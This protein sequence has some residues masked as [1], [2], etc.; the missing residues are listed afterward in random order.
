MKS[1]KLPACVLFII[2]AAAFVMAWGFPARALRASYFPLLF[3]GVGI[4][5]SAYLFISAVWKERAKEDKPGPQL[6]LSTKILVLCTGVLISLYV[7]SMVYIGFVL[8]TMIFMVITIIYL[9][10][11]KLSG[12]SIFLA[13]FISGCTTGIIYFVF[14]NILLI[15]L[16]VGSLF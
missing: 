16:P 4:L 8:S 11:N 6:D 9:N 7:M 13:V 5:L 14:Q 1:D 3:S 2:F 12:K 15:P 10:P